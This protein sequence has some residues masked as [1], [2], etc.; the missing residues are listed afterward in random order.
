M[1]RELDERVAKA[2]GWE[3][4][5]SPAVGW[6]QRPGPNGVEVLYG[7]PGYSSNIMASRTMEDWI[8]KQE[9]S[10]WARYA[11]GLCSVFL[12]DGTG[13]DLPDFDESLWWMFVRATPEQRCRAFLAAME[14]TCDNS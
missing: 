2:M 7:L 13:E 12:Q 6:G 11:Q 8:E 14:A 3:R 5:Q 1:S 9:G 10:L 4:M